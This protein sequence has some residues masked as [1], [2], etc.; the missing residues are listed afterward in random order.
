MGKHEKICYKSDKSYN[1][2]VLKNDMEETVIIILKGTQSVSE[3]IEMW[4]EICDLKE[5]VLLCTAF[6]ENK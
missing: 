4:V 5:S 1:T 6:I 2:S 3:S